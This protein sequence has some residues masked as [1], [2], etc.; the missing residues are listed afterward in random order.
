MMNVFHRILTP[1]L[2]ALCTLSACAEPR[3][4][5][6][7]FFHQSFNN[8]MEE[9]E[10]VKQQNLTGLF[11]MFS[12]DDCPWCQKMKASVMNQPLIQDYYRSHFRVLHIDIRGDT[13]VTNFNGV[14]LSEKDFA[15]RIHRV[16]ATPVFIFFDPKGNPIQRFTGAT[17]D[18]DE[19]LWLA[20]FV[21]SGEYRHTNFTRYKRHRR[22]MSH[23]NGPSR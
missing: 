23:L 7:Y 15:F 12:D 4:P 2:L 14:E 1:A 16:R 20:E 17:R 9:A 10:V 22:D 11:V 21:V 3:N 6:Q 18:V 19:F 13:F 5:E 8:L